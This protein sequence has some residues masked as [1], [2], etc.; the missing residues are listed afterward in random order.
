V[1]LCEPLIVNASAL[2]VQEAS[3]TMGDDD[4]ADADF[5]GSQPASILCERRTELH[6]RPDRV[7]T[8]HSW[9]CSAYFEWPENEGHPGCRK[10]R[11]IICLSWTTLRVDGEQTAPFLPPRNL[12]TFFF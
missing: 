4:E 3:P 2:A 8:E 10:H 7:M 5:W 1:C 9:S 11:K 12:H 6:D